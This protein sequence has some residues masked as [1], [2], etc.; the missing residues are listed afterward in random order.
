MNITNDSTG[1]PDFISY[2][3]KQFLTDLGTMA[4]LRDELA[5]RQGA[6]S[7]VEAT[8]KTKAD[9]DVY[10]EAKKVDAD[11][12]LE[13]AKLSKDT[14]EVLVADLKAKGIELDARVGVVETELAQREKEVAS[15]EKKVQANENVVDLRFKEIQ[16]ENEKLASATAALDAR[17][18]AFQDSIKN[19]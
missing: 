14:A 8:I 4:Q 18:K 19:I 1:S 7:V 6:L 3:T 13:K 11:A 9:A 15:R 2:F 10:A 17:I 12:I 5:T 16:L